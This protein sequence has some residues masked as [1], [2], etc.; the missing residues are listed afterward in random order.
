MGPIN[1]ISIFHF[2]ISHS[3]LVIVNTPSC[4]FPNTF[5]VELSQMIWHTASGAL[6]VLGA[7]AA[8]ITQSGFRDNDCSPIEHFCNTSYITVHCICDQ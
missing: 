7:E 2:Q 8:G 1:R 5:T 6:Q 4:K 3:L